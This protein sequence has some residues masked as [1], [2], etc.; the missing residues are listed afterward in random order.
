ME[1]QTFSKEEKEEIIRYGLDRIKSICTMTFVTLLMGCIFQVFFQSI[2]FLVCFIALRKYAG[3]YHADT[4]NR[5]YVISTAIIAVALLA[6]R[7]MSD[8]SDNEIFILLQNLNF[9]LLYFLVPVD[10]KNH[11]LEYWE[12]EKY[13]KKQE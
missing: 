1:T 3:G 7:Y 4:Q 2:I 11:R 12:K 13:G 9:I 5:C 8:G 10:N 6:I